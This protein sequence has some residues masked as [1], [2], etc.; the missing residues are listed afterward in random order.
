MRACCVKYV[1]DGNYKWK[2]YED[3][4]SFRKGC[5]KGARC[6]Y[7]HPRL[8]VSF[9]VVAASTILTLSHPL[10]PFVDACVAAGGVACG[11]TGADV[12]T[13]FEVPC[14]ARECITSLRRSLVRN[15][16]LVHVAPG[17]LEAS[18]TLWNM[19][20]QADRFGESSAAAQAAESQIG[21][22]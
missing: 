14:F 5:D 15:S 4:Y 7:D 11:V 22:I 10:G 21:S 19:L 1:A 18:D 16:H 20:E 3:E 2:E 6:G 12:A 9:D 13:R 8:T 17:A